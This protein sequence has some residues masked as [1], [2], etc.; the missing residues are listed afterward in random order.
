MQNELIRTNIENFTDFLKDESRTIG[1]ADSIS[2][3]GTRQDLHRIINT[4][5]NDHTAITIQGSR[6]GITGGAV[7]YGGHILNMSKMNRILALSRADGNDEFYIDV[8]PGLLLTDLRKALEE[9][10]IDTSGWSPESLQAF[11][12][13]K[14]KD[15]YFFPP[16]PTETSAS[17]GG[18][19]ACNASGARSFHY[20]P[21]RQYIQALTILLIDGSTLYLERGNQKASGR[22]FVLTTDTGKTFKGE[23]PAYTMPEVK[24]ASG[25]FIKGNMD[26]IDLFIGSEGTLGILLE[27]RLRL[28]PSPKIV[29]GL[30][31]FL[32]DEEQAIT[33][34]RQ[35]R[36]EPSSLSHKPLVIR[37]SAIEFF[38]S[39]ALALLSTMK[40]SYPAFSS[41]PGV[42]D[43]SC[44]AV[45]IELHAD[46]EDI[47][48]DS[49]LHIS[50]LIAD[51]GGDEDS[52]WFAT[53]P[54]EMEQLLSFR[55][56]IP[57]AVNLYLDMKKK[58]GLSITKL[59][60]DMAVADDKLTDVYRLY[61]STL[62]ENN[63]HYVMFGHIG[64]N[65]IHVNILPE[66]EEEYTRGKA[67]YKSWAEKILYW[68]GTV[69]AE[70]GIG[71]LKK[72]FLTMMY[73]EQG[74][75]EMLGLK[76]IFD[77]GMLLNP[78]NL[79]S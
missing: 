31:C 78:G 21:T 36:G 38:D 50:T 40:T 27:A 64:D 6:T 22:N 74:I 2:F 41:L 72:D 56:A 77:P 52:T 68:G 28:I 35:C 25:Y 62:K 20:G 79:F 60:T 5:K 55:H 67:L 1:T 19:I 42:P 23:L 45:Y 7:P 58:E 59:G 24:N 71:K 15:T 44:S 8:Q 10:N 51:C 17:I 63:L 11:S 26:L 29:W 9:K 18:M 65:H 43:Q 66:T 39:R 47:L 32:P 14:E 53:S 16:D 57:E 61:H 33:F 75:A 69:S 70:H 46:N 54:R 73:H 4:L 30:T 37:P 34:V 13:L 3:P 48:Q 76:K 12:L 49:L